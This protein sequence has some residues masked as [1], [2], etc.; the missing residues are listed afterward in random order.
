V[1]EIESSFIA[2]GSGYVHITSKLNIVTRFAGEAVSEDT[3]EI[4]T[5]A[6]SVIPF[7]TLDSTHDLI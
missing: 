1:S 4:H 7:S 6:I 5:R 2:F 3:S